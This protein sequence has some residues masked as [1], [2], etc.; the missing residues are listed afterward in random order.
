MS[1]KETFVDS[2]GRSKVLSFRFHREARMRYRVAS[3]EELQVDEFDRLRQLVEHFLARQVPRVQELMDYAQGNNHTVSVSE[4]RQEQDM[5]DNRAVH[6][7]GG[8]MSVFKQGYLV[9]TP[10]QVAYNDETEDSAIDQYLLELATV[11]QFA[12]LNRALV[13]DLSRTGRA[14]ELVY[15]SQADVTRVKRLDPR[16]A[17]VIYGQD[18]E[19]VPL[20]GVRVYRPDFLTPNLYRVEL[21]T[22]DQVFVFSYD[23]QLT[24]S[25]SGFHAF[26]DVPIVEYLNT[27]EGLG[28]YET[29]LSLIDLYDASQS[30]TANY[31]TD[32]A[33]AILAIFGRVSFPP[34]VATAEQRIDYMKKMRKARLMNLE[35]PTDENGKEGQVGAQYLYKQYDVAGTEAYKSRIVSD[36]HKFT[37][38]PDMTDEHF[39]GSQSGEA[40]K[41]KVFGLEQE[42]VTTQALFETSLRRRYQLLVNI[43][44]VLTVVKDFDPTKLGITF[45][46]NLPADVGNLINQ[47]KQLYGVVSDQT[48]FELLEGAT[49]V[50]AKV[51]QDR[52]KAKEEVSPALFRLGGY[53]DGQTKD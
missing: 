45:T 53:D 38:I 2:T 37:N 13:L 34:T 35:P 39:S 28:D 9:G 16:E 5:A 24:L 15:R 44:R 25:D 42:R 18:I 27:D 1:Y 21:Y 3:V 10:I 19:E 7:F 17:F 12:N 49:G 46:P 20:A 43:G 26:G 50:R 48:V 40:M 29:I 11:N 47:A 8:M 23:G 6:N 14:F 22:A 4:R 31:M 33:D 41:W 36:I 51:E 30:D 32:L 52:L